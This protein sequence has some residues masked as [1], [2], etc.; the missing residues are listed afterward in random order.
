MDFK[1]LPAAALRWLRRFRCLAVM[2]L[3]GLT[4]RE[5]YPFSHFPMYSTFSSRTYFIYLSN[6]AGEPR[7]NPRSGPLQFR[8]KKSST[9][10][11]GKNFS[12]LPMREISGCHWRKRPLARIF[13]IISMA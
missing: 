8:L 12:A 9:D 5:N 10:T 6:S 2:V 1:S 11:G 3:L 13:C 4:L 7:Q